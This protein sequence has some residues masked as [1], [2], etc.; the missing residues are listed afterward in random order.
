MD[1]RE[2]TNR[3]KTAVGGARPDSDTLWED[4]MTGS[5]RAHRARAARRTGA[6]LTI[7]ALAIAVPVAIRLA[8]SDRDPTFAEPG[9]DSP[10]P[11]PVLTATATPSADPW[12]DLNYVDTRMNISLQ[13]PSTYR[14]GDFEGHVD[15]H[16]TSLPGPVEGGDTAFVEI[17]TGGTPDMAFGEDAAKVV[18]DSIGGAP[19]QR[20]D[21][22]TERGGP[23]SVWFV[24]KW[25]L[26]PSQSNSACCLDGSPTL[27]VILEAS[28]PRLAANHE[29]IL[30]LIVASI[31][32]A[33][34]G[35]AELRA[36]T[37]R[38]SIA[39]NVEFARPV[40]WVATF[41][42][43]RITMDDPERLL[44]APALRE[45]TAKELPSSEP[46][47]TP[48]PDGYYADYVIESVEAV[49]A[50]SFQV[51]VTLHYVDLRRRVTQIHETLFVGPE[52][53][54]IRGFEGRVGT[55]TGGPAVESGKAEPSFAP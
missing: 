26:H 40:L 20:L 31:A 27:V 52:D 53:A 30:R 42:D 9:D 2:L 21:T 3:L 50:N 41:L 55:T 8:G 35:I 24:P 46:W 25:V 13:L 39:G 37:R 28:T 29:E 11:T 1:E 18:D 54:P 22:T 17:F 33:G 19:A 44:S 23:R 10:T 15:F 51:Q 48:G 47:L 38:G 32:P 36:D 16:P 4:I 5:N 43:D 12:F 7:A 6:A 14:H 49:D 34:G 45:Y